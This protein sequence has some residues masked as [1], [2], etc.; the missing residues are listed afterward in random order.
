MNLTFRDKAITGIL[1]VLPSKVVKFED[2]MEN[3]NFSK[4]KCGYS[5]PVHQYTN[6]LN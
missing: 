6:M 1:T 2:E 4:A 5:D 3:Y